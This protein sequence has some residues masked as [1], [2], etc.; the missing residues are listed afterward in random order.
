MTKQA[1]LNTQNKYVR[2]EAK[3]I[4]D[5]SMV[6][7]VKKLSIQDQIP[8]NELM[9][10]AIQLLFAKHHL[11]L[12]GNPQLTLLTFGNAPLIRLGKCSINSCHANAVYAG[13]N[14]QTGESRKFCAKCFKNV[15]NRHDQK[16]W[17]WDVKPNG[18][19][20]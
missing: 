19:K 11:D 1:N 14:L 13:E 6:K 15:P 16:V 9:K 18:G 5:E 3:T 20:S 12:G 2:F 8:V 17:V 4:E 10:E 7:N